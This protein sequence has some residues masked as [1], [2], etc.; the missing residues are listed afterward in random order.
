MKKNFAAA[1]F[2][3]ALLAWY[4]KHKRRLPWR[5]ERDPYRIWISEVMLQQTRVAVVQDRYQEFLRLF[6][7]LPI[8]ARAPRAKVL[9]AWSGLGYYRRAL[10]LH[11]AA[12]LLARRG[13][14]LPRGAEQLRQLPGIGRYTAAAIASIAFGERTAVVDG[15]VERV[16]GRL[17][18]KPE[19][20]Q[21]ATS[22]NSS[23][24]CNP[25]QLAQELLDQKR[26]GDFN[27]AMMELGATLCHPLNPDCAACPV[28]RFC[29]GR[30]K[31]RPQ[32]R[33]TEMRRRVREKYLVLCR[34][35]RVYL[36]RR[37]TG[38]SLM[39]GMWELP[40]TRAKVSGETVRARHSITNT[41]FEVSAVIR[42]G[43]VAGM[44]DGK[45]ISL[46]RLPQ[47]PLTGLTRKL[48]RQVLPVATRH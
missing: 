32:N 46:A 9:A 48:L 4:G 6:P 18:A 42:R 17:F 31:V 36:V 44:K 29:A 7:T 41:N 43:G 16:L 8:L 24:P 5:G 2:R 25:W 12:Q 33:K 14:L 45:W 26:P 30:G 34:K 20:G 13:Q 1:R 22:S 21:P 19:R 15:N 39:P 28:A 47:V 40:Q 3:H 23:E 11:N 38:E 27:Q 35:H 37:A 10:N